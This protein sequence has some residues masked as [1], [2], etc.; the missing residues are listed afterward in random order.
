[1]LDFGVAKVKD[2]AKVTM[3]KTGVGTLIGTPHYMSPEQVKGIGEVDYRADLWA[4]GVIAFQCVT[5]ELPY[6]SEGVGDLLIKITIGESP[7]PSHVYPAAHANFD[8]WFAKA[9]AREPAKRFQSAREMAL[10][11]AGVVGVIDGI[12]PRAPTVRPPPAELPALGLPRPPRAMTEAL[13]AADWEEVDAS[14]HHQPAAAEAPVPSSKAP[15]IVAAPRAPPAESHDSHDIVDF[16]ETIPAHD[17]NG[18]SLMLPLMSRTG[19]RGGQGPVEEPPRS[20]PPAPPPPGPPPSSAPGRAGPPS[21]PASRPQALIAPVVMQSPRS[22]I[23]PAPSPEAIPRPPPSP[24]SLAPQVSARPSAVPVVA[25]PRNGP[26]L[27]IPPPEFDGLSRRRRLVRFMLAGLVLFAV[28]IT[29]SVVRSQID[30]SPAAPIPPAPTA[31]T[32]AAPLP[33]PPPTVAT[34]SAVDPGKVTHPTKPAPSVHH[35]TAPIRPRAP[36]PP[37]EGT[38]VVPDPPDD[39]PTP[40]P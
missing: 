2:A 40:A 33:E 8:T 29:W 28:G 13:D 14:D 35:N 30:L 1:M 36:K 18:P 5:G 16:D 7:I 11:L 37:A 31:T 19:P 10:A 32:A 21:A 38:I 3:Q 34:S 6:D 25:P 17:L 26:L 22:A 9:C 4:L 20:A 39:D 23:A 12:A 24:R 27:T 15:A